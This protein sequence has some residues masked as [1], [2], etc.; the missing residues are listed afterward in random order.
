MHSRVLVTWILLVTFVSAL[1]LNLKR[2]VGTQG[3]LHNWAHLFVFAFTVLLFC[4]R[5]S[6]LSS[7]IARSGLAILFA[8]S[9]EGMQAIVYRNEFEWHDLW[10]DSVGVLIGLAFVISMRP[11]LEFAQR[12]NSEK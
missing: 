1:P 10:V 3:L 5:R 8:I 6:S 9:L 7:K 12:S 2:L 4:W 11:V